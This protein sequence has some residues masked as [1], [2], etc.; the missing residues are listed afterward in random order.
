MQLATSH[1]VPPRSSSSHLPANRRVRGQPAAIHC[2]ISLRRHRSSAPILIAAGIAP[3][4]FNRRT[5]RRL[6]P[7]SSDTPPTSSTSCRGSD[8]FSSAI[9]IPS[10]KTRPAPRRSHD[11]IITHRTDKTRFAILS[12]A[13]RN[14]GKT[15]KAYDFRRMPGITEP[16]GINRAL[17]DTQF[18]EFVRR[19]RLRTRS[20]AFLIVDVFTPN[21]A[22]HSAKVR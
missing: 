12:G 17:L 3:A 13:V 6:Q 20:Q 9:T 18:A 7:S 5:V 16:D 22:A 2:S 10:P 8:L 11:G 15:P 21:A 4:S 14:D 1:C 19:W